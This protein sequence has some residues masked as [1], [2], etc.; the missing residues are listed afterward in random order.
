MRVRIPL[1]YNWRNLFV[2]RV[3]AVMTTLGIALVVAVFLLVMALATGVRRTFE[4]R[5]SPVD[6]VVTRIGAQSDVQSI[7]SQTELD[8]LRTLPGI[9]RGKNGEPL[10]SPEIVLLINLARRDGK[11]TNVVVRGVRPVA[12]EMRPALKIVEGRLPQAGTDEAVVARRT[13]DRFA[14]LALGST[15]RSGAERWKLVGVFEADGSP[16]DSE[17]WAD[18]ENTQ[19]QARRTG[20]FS[21]VRMRAVDLEARER[22]QSAVR[23]DQRL[24]LDAKPESVFFAEQTGTAKP[25][26]FLAYLV[27][28]I[29]AVGASF[30]AM[31]TMYAQVTSRT[32]EIATMRA[33]GYGR[34]A[35]LVSFVLESMW[36]SLVGGALGAALAFGIVRTFLA[37]PAGTQNVATFAEILF[38]FELTPELMVQ[39]VLA[40]LVIGVLGGILP[41]FRASRMEITSALRQA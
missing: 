36:L 38:Q 26:E 29:M 33:L 24:K 5:S 20:I 3:S 6:V 9:A 31:N 13:R 18:L 23:G 21:I 41:A 8:T 10:V 17:I 32:R 7:I 34:A 27:G 37:A 28:A 16:F 12:F 22:L 25:I 19:G 35:I 1:R 11:R 15:V 4:V 14:G 2:R 39:G 40:S 30:G